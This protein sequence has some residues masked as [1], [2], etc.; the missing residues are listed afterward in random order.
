[1]TRRLLAA[2]FLVVGIVLSPLRAAAATIPVLFAYDAAVRPTATTAF[3]NL[4]DPPLNKISPISPLTAVLGSPEGVE[5]TVVEGVSTI[6][7]SLVRFTQDTVSSRFRCLSRWLTRPIRP[8]HVK[9]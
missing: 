2:L 6:D 4:Y 5:S 1:V 7:T 9:S 3:H 8:S